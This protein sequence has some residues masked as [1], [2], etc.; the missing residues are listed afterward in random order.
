VYA[1]F[2]LYP[3]PVR[4][5]GLIVLSLL[6]LGA[7]FAAGCGEPAVTPTT[8][9]P[10]TDT[11]SAQTTSSTAVTTPATSP[12]LS[13][14][15]VALAGMTLRAK[16]AQV[17]LVSFDGTSLTGTDKSMFSQ[18]T[19]GGVLLLGRNVTGAAQLRSLTASLQL[20][21]AAAGAPGLFVAADEEGGPVMRV[22][23]GVPNVP[24]ARVLG[25]TSSPAH[26]QALAQATA[27]GLLA[28]GVNMVLAP[29]ADVVRDKDSFLFSR[30]YGGDP[31]TVSDFVEAVTQGFVGSG[32]VTV[33]K[34][35]PGHGSA[36]GNSHTSLPVS[37]ATRAD[38]ETI[39]LLPFEVAIAAGADGVMIGHLSVPAYDALHVASQSAPMIEDLLRRDLGFEGLAVSDDLEMAAAVGR[40]GEVGTASAAELGD[41][42]VASLAAGCDLLITTST[43]ARQ[44]AIEQAIVDAVSTGA[45]SD[46]RLDQAVM[47]ILLVKAEHSLL[48]PG[49]APRSN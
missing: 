40:A 24:A 35:F 41:A 20:E 9:A 34:H 21:A 45:L 39:H 16:A 32:V 10:S 19:P 29:V 6:V 15:Q 17:L 31:G 14:V 8:G 47:R 33:V 3:L 43:F 28:Q 2:S 48:L 22:K 23:D 5:A 44:S 42:A 49:A 7:A 11:T 12:S 37:A 46:E 25:T 18:T 38:F 13:R 1:Q 4:Y 26:A 36:P 27:A 30:S